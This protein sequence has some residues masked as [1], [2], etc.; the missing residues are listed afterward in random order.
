[1]LYSMY[2]AMLGFLK[3]ETGR[4]HEVLCF[5]YIFEYETFRW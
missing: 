5:S 4:L 2:K 1:M 3:H